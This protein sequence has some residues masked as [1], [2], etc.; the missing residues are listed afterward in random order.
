MFNLKENENYLDY[1]FA[2]FWIVVFCVRLFNRRRYDSVLWNHR[3]PS[4]PYRL[5]GETLAG[6][7]V[8]YG[9]KSIR[10]RLLRPAA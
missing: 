5:L 9:K 10:Q 4:W 1:S 6:G 2:C 3:A 8:G 7:E